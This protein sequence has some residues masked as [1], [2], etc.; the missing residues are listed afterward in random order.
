MTGWL[1]P[2]TGETFISETTVMSLQDL[3]Y[4]VQYSIPEPSTLA[5]LSLAVLLPLTHRKR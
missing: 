2:D 1:G 5:L 3:G 4:M